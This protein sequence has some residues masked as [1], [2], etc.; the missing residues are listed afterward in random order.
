[1]VYVQNLYLFYKN[2]TYIQFKSHIKIH[3][4]CFP[5]AVEKLRRILLINYKNMLNK[6]YNI[7][8]QIFGLI[9]KPTSPRVR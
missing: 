8:E 4:P 3:Q 2:K 6:K 5:S 1:M 7:D 9:K